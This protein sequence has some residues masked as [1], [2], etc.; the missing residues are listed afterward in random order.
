MNKITSE[1]TPEEIEEITKEM[2]E[3]EKKKKS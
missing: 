3:E 2:L 1:L